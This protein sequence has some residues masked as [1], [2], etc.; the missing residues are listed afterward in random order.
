MNDL[1]KRQIIRQ[2]VIDSNYK[3]PQQ[4]D[5]GIMFYKGLR[6]TIDEFNS[7]KRLLL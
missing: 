4:L 1:E 3:W 5:S 7:E 6:I 2:A